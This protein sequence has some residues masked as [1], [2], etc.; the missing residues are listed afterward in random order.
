MTKM[1]MH[2]NQLH[3]NY[4]NKTTYID[5]S[6][7]CWRCPPDC[8]RWGEVGSWNCWAECSP[9]LEHSAHSLSGLELSDCSLLQMKPVAQRVSVHFQ[10]TSFT[11]PTNTTKYSLKVA[12]RC[13]KHTL[14][15]GLVCNMHLVK[16][17]TRVFYIYFFFILLFLLN[18]GSLEIDIS[19]LSLT[20]NNIQWQSKCS[21]GAFQAFK[22]L[23]QWT[24]NSNVASNSEMRNSIINTEPARYRFSTLNSAQTCCCWQSKQQPSTCSQNINSGPNKLLTRSF[25]G[26]QL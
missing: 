16:H 19:C 7:R 23:S 4:N 12:G 3:Q 15:L 14:F 1:T 20:F 17:L 22:H 24:N 21:T 25:S 13:W 11:S 18:F 10:T 6:R 5:H 2:V 8:G 9:Q 26:H